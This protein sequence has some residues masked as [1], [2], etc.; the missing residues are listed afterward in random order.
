M[1]RQ[2]EETPILLGEDARKFERDIKENETRKV[3]EEEYKRVMQV[4]HSVKICDEF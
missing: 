2:I 1:A 3:S 4:F